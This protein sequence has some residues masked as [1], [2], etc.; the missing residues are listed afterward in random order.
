M[1]V[2][3]VRSYIGNFAVIEDYRLFGYIANSGIR[4]V[5]CTDD[6]EPVSK[7]NMKAYCEAIQ[8]AYIDYAAN[9]FVEE[10][11]TI[12]SK[13]FDARVERVTEQVFGSTV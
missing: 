11:A 7:P 5:L 3:P 1:C 8:Q 6:G 9:P 10:G 4:I 2:C 13:N 12:V